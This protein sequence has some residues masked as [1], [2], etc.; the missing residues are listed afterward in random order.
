MLVVAVPP[1]RRR[2]DWPVTPNR[3]MVASMPTDPSSARDRRGAR[4]TARH[5][6]AA[7][8]LA[9]IA[10]AA[11]VHAAAPDERAEERHALVEG[12]RRQWSTLA[13]NE[14][15]LGAPN[16]RILA[17]IE[18]VPR[19]E[20]VPEPVR[21]GA[22]EDRPLSIGEGQTISQPFI[23]ALMTALADPDADDV[24]L[25]VGTGSGYQAAVLAR[26]VERVYTI[27]IVEPL[28]RRAAADLAR[29]G[30]DNVQARTGDGYAGWPEHA[31]FDAI[32][33]T[34]AAPEIPQ[35]LVE[36]LKSVTGRLVIPVDAA[37]GQDLLVVSKNADG[38]LQKRM[39][40]P[41]RFV[42][43]T[44]QAREPATAPAE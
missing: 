25:E 33:V 8:G 29:L 19:H 13:E 18:Q 4:C 44:G 41:V 2:P 32:V 39:V 16:E 20:L 21:P 5:L 10:V 11:T 27:E 6:A 12:I 43:L 34:A 22:Y 1:D 37:Y 35:P 24:V 15:A 42:P 23:V 9:A 17:A 14:P 31:P 38:T 3:R 30:V 40:L 36:Q 28:A 7:A 26:L